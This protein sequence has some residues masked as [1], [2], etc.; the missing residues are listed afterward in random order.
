MELTGSSRDW[1]ARRLKQS[2][3]EAKE[4]LKINVKKLIIRTRGWK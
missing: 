1:G 3:E 4:T 2:L